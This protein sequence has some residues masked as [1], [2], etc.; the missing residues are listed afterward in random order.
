MPHFTPSSSEVW[1]CYDSYVTPSTP[2]ASTGNNGDDSSIDLSIT[3]AN[4]AMTPEQEFLS[5]AMKVPRSQLHGIDLM[6]SSD[7][8]D[9][10]E[11]KEV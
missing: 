4:G 8:I 7:S 1:D 3:D 11:S 2:Q 9:F 10:N 6:K 5:Y